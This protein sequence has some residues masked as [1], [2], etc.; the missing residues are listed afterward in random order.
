MMLIPFHFWI[1]VFVSPQRFSCRFVLFRCNFICNILSPPLK[2]TPNTYVNNIT[3]K[4][5]CRYFIFVQLDLRIFQAERFLLTW[6]ISTKF[7]GKKAL[8]F[9]KTLSSSF[10]SFLIFFFRLIPWQYPELP[11]QSD[12]NSCAFHLLHN[13]IPLNQCCDHND[14]TLMYLPI[15][16]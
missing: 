7:P 6:T 9:S 11:F 5:H 12:I 13:H 15:H 1:I 10:F 14:D 3:S 8:D 2:S 16:L 4:A